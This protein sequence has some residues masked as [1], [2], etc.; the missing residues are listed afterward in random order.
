MIGVPPVRALLT[1]LAEVAGLGLIV[2][3]IGL[4]SVPF[5]LIAAGVGLIAIGLVQA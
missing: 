3:G 1:T 4:V 2:A 5:A